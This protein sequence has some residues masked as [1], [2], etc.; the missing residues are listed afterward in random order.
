MKQNTEKFFQKRKLIMALPVL[1]MPFVTM[2][3]WA[4][5]G[6]SGTDTEEN[7]VAKDGL[8][9]EL[10]NAQ[11]SEDA[12]A[13]E[14]LSL[15]Q[16]AQRDSM[17]RNQVRNNDPYFKLNRL[18]V[19]RDSN[20]RNANHD[21]LPRLN[22]SLGSRNHS[23]DANQAMMKRKMAELYKAIN[24]T[25]QPINS[26]GSRSDDLKNS[27][28][29]LGITSDV[30]RL[31]GMMEMMQAKGGNDEE[32]K[33]IQSMLDK[34]LDIQHPE[35]VNERLR[36]QST[37]NPR[38]V[39][40]VSI[41]SDES[42][43]LM[44]NQSDEIDSASTGTIEANQF[45][46]LDIRNSV[47]SVPNTFAAEIYG[48]QALIAGSIVK[49]KLN[50]DILINGTYIPK[51]QLVYGVCALNGERLTVKIN[52]IRSGAAIF[53]VSLDVF[54]LDGLEGIYIPGALARSVAKQS[55]NEAVSDVQLNTLD[56]TLEMQ[57]ANAGVETV[58]NLLR[59]KTTLIKVTVK[60]GYK[61]L[62]RD[63]SQS[64]E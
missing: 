37:N 55:S 1:T 39:F 18:E 62:L 7:I 22:S 50:D 3:F 41:K 5:G 52:S 45:Y 64:K 11:L 21:S 19:Q 59:K 40:G 16:K 8:N 54:D 9:T 48:T 31:E 24:K 30:D 51:N 42:V 53:P 25:S 14:K 38:M 56:P 28:E 63:S 43:G 26:D 6:G 57:A 61:I 27:D 47:A 32:M 49:L 35:R 23:T 58:K 10:P 33:E 34:V 12:K 36:E 29:V 44:Q 46:G 13:W 60:A 4:L 15:Y 20:K 2:L 17:K